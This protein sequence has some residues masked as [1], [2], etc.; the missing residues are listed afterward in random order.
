MIV[1]E[2]EQKKSMEQERKHE[3]VHFMTSASKEVSLL[4]DYTNSI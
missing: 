1:R 3:W 2:W 4:S